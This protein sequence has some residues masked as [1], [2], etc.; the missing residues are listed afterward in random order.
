[1]RASI[2]WL[3]AVA[4][5]SLALWPAAADARSLDA[6]SDGVALHAYHAYLQDLVSVGPAWSQADDAYLASVSS[7]CPNV[8]EALKHARPGTFSQSALLRFGIEAGGDLDAVAYPL[9]QPALAKLAATLD[10]LRWSGAGDKAA[11]KGYL[12]AEGSLLHLTPSDLCSDARA[13]AASHGRHVPHSTIAWVRKFAHRANAAADDGSAF[14]TVLQRSATPAQSGAVK[15]ITR[16][17]NRFDS[18]VQ[19]RAL[20]A[21]KKLLKV[22]GIYG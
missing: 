15:G 8:L 21:G 12:A 7:Q 11:I 19:N 17:L 3:L 20:T 1:V 14:L 13:L 6:R 9:A 5:A 4:V 16:L 18:S 22:L 2:R 10:P